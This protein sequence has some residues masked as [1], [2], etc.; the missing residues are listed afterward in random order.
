MNINSSLFDVHAPIPGTSFVFILNSSSAQIGSN[1]RDVLLLED[2]ELG[3][4]PSGF[5]SG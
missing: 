5:Y 1:L 2:V 4:K 3:A